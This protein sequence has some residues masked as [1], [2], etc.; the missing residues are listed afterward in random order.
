MEQ[1]QINSSAY[2]LIDN[3]A[4]KIK[5]IAEK[6]GSEKSAKPSKS[7]QHFNPWW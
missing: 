7:K 5:D 6:K 3:K 1:K 2:R 4:K